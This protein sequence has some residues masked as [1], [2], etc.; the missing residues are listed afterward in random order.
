M[1]LINSDITIELKMR[2]KLIFTIFVLIFF[3]TDSFRVP[4]KTEETNG[5]L[6]NIHDANKNQNQSSTDI[7]AS[8]LQ[9]GIIRGMP[10]IGSRPFYVQLHSRSEGFFCAGSVLSALW[11]ITT[12]Q[13]VQ[14][15]SKSRR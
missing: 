2:L 9:S 4:L 1:I 15:R 6:L 10:V 7:V 5:N 12:A 13:C 14:K 11:V 8:H 3:K